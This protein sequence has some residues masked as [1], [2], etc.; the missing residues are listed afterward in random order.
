MEAHVISNP[1][2]G[3]GRSF[4]WQGYGLYFLGFT[5]YHTDRIP[6]EGSH[7]DWTTLFWT[8]EA[9]TGSN[10]K[11]EAKNAHKR[12]PFPPRQCTSPHFTG[13]HGN[14]SRWFPI[15]HIC[16][17][18]PPRLPSFSPDKKKALA[19]CHFASD[20]DVIAAAKGFL[21]PKQKSSSTLG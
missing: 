2:E 15:H 13:C 8:N 12:S 18:W 9:P 16:Q 1:K 3:Q 6:S 21:S 11:K 20:D 14:N 19:G 10:Q 17:T 7:S 4:I 5:G